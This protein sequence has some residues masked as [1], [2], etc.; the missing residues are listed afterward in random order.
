MALFCLMETRATL[1]PVTRGVL[2]KPAA[3]FG[4]HDIEDEANMRASDGDIRRDVG[5]AVVLGKRGERS[6]EMLG[7]VGNHAPRAS[8]AWP[9]CRENVFVLVDP[10]GFQPG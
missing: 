6:D 1:G 8:K 5:N 2:L 10:A 4:L 3:I 7:V 9:K